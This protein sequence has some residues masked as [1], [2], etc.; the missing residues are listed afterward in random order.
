MSKKLSLTHTISRHGYK[1]EIRVRKELGFHLI[2]RVPPRRT[3]LNNITLEILD[4]SSAQKFAKAIELAL[5]GKYSEYSQRFCKEIEGV[6]P[7]DVHKDN[8]QW[9]ATQTMKFSRDTHLSLDKDLWIMIKVEQEASFGWRSSHP[10]SIFWK[11]ILRASE[12]KSISNAMYE[13]FGR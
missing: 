9:V 5:K 3:Q 13:F 4:E 7:D 6:C 11:M 2:L 10:S 8:H 1:L 12:L